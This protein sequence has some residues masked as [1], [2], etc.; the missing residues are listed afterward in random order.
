VPFLIL[1]GT[2][3]AGLPTTFLA[4]GLATDF[5]GDLEGFAEIDE[6]MPRLSALEHLHLLVLPGLA[7][8][9]LGTCIA[10]ILAREPVLRRL[11]LVRPRAGWAWMP[12]YALASFSAGA[13]GVFMAGLFFDTTSPHLE[14][15]SELI[16]EPRGLGAAYVILCLSLIPGIAEELLYRGY[17]QQRLQRRWP[18]P[19][20]ILA[21]GVVFA[22][23]HLD[24][25][26]SLAVLPA[27]LWFSFVAWATRSVVP[28]MLCH[29]VYNAGMMLLGRLAPEAALMPPAA[30]AAV[31]AVLCA[32]AGSL[33]LSVPVL[34]RAGLRRP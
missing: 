29:A 4:Y 13:L 33:V 5:R 26:H 22:L 16:L 14:A 15:L 19:L 6:W 2:I 31:L 7:L 11:G 21:A 17:M 34:L 27:G 3:C 32:S 1:G 20:A 9:F 28:S 30:G 8:I 24:P 25:Q 23:S 10:G 12:F 18:A